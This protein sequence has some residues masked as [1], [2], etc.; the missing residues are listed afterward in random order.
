M[1]YIIPILI[2]SILKLPSFAQI[3]NY[4][5]SAK[6]KE[7]LENEQLIYRMSQN[8]DSMGYTKAI[9]FV[10]NIEAGYKEEVSAIFS[11][12]LM[13]EQINCVY[14]LQND[15]FKS[16]ESD[17]T[18]A[19]NTFK[20]KGNWLDS[21]KIQVKVNSLDTLLI[22]DEHLERT[23]SIFILPRLIYNK[24]INVRY[25]QF[26]SMDLRFRQISASVD[27]SEKHIS[28]KFGVKNCSVVSLKGGVAEQD[29][30]VDK[31]TSRIV[32]IVI[33]A[34]GWEYDLIDIRSN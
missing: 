18:Y 6:L 8:G 12:K 10:N 7:T 9:Y 25:L 22:P 23:F 26:N 2:I 1:K 30:Y 11:G 5:S 32:R 13:E 20:F 19:G 28:T 3:G 15:K 14:D 33:P 17:I 27:T 16:A 24:D 4:I 34:M 31:E 21:N 29:I